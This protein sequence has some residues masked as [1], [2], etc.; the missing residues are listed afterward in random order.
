MSTFRSSTLRWFFITADCWKYFSAAK[1]ISIHSGSSPAIY[2]SWCGSRLD[3][4]STHPHSHASTTLQKPLTSIVFFVKC[5][6]QTHHIAFRH[7][8]Q[9]KNSLTNLF[10][11]SW[12]RISICNLSVNSCNTSE[13]P[14]LPCHTCILS[15]CQSLVYHKRHLVLHANRLTE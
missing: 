10:C 9:I 7:T 8:I 6:L 11:L 1:D 5:Y 3:H 13:I 15:E 2:Y 12:I 4:H 14:A